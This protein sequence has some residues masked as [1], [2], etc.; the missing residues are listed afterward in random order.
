MNQVEEFKSLM[1]DF[2]KL[3]TKVQDNNT[4]L[5]EKNKEKDMII[6]ACQKEYQ[7]IYFQY[8]DVKEKL[9]LAEQKINELEQKKKK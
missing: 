6:K 2:G 7:K 9:K 5:K 1:N 8:E 4:A 3:N